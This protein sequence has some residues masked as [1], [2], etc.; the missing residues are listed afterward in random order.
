MKPGDGRWPVPDEVHWPTEW[1]EYTSLR[2][3]WKGKS[4]WTW[5]GNLDYE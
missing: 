3:R 4:F 5:V 1:E 2:E